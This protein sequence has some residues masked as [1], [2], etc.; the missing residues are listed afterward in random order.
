[1]NWDI[2]AKKVGPGFSNLLKCNPFNPLQFCPSMFLPDF[3][4]FSLS[5]SI[6]LSHY[7]DILVNSMAILISAE[8]A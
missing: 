8:I 7:C 2:L 3:L 1:M 5:S 4:V 6:V